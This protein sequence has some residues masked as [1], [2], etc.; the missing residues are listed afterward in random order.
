MR[1]NYVVVTMEDTRAVS[2]L[3]VLHAP[4]SDGRRHGVKEVFFLTGDSP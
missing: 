2:I 1:A 4:R 3:R